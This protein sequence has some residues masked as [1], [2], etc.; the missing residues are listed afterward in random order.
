VNPL[1]ATPTVPGH[2]LLQVIGK[3]NSGEVWLAQTITGSLRAVK[4]V[5]PDQFDNLRSYERELEGV[6]RFEP[7]SRQHESLMDV[8]HVGEDA[9][10]RCF[11]CVME[12]ADSIAGSPGYT[13]LTLR[14]HLSTK[15]RLP[16]TE[17]IEI[18]RRLAEGL[19]FL[20]EHGL[21]HRDVK[22]GNVIFCRGQ[23]K[24]ADVGLV[25]GSDA[26]L[27]FVGTEGYFPPEGPG[28]P[29]ADLYSLG[30]VI[31]E[32]ATGKHRCE[33]PA[34][35]ASFTDSTE[36]QAFAEL[37]EIILKACAT[38]PESRYQTAAELRRDLLLLQA[39]RSITQQRLAERRL[40]R[41]KRLGIGAAIVLLV[42][43][44]AVGVQRRA[45]AK[46]RQDQLADEK[47]AAEE[48][49]RSRRIATSERETRA[50]LYAADLS[51]AASALEYGA[52]GRAVA[53]LE[54]HLPTSGQPDL[55]GIEWRLLRRKC[56]S[57]PHQVIQAHPGGVRAMILS[58][59]GK[60][61]YSTGRDRTLRAFS[62]ASGDAIKSWALP[63]AE[64]TSMAIHPSS[65][66]LA[67]AGG[68]EGGIGLLDLATGNL[69][70]QALSANYQVGFSPDGTMVLV[71]LAARDHGT[72]GW[73]EMFDLE[74]RPVR[75][76]ATSGCRFAFSPK[77]TSLATGPWDELVKLWSWPELQ[78]VREL[79]R[80]AEVMSLE[81]APDGRALA[82]G[83][84]WGELSR[85]DTES[86]IKPTRGG[87]RVTFDTVTWSPD[88][89]SV[90]TTFNQKVAIFDAE[91]L[92]LREQFVGHEKTVFSVRWTRDGRKIISASADGT[93]R[94]W[95][96]KPPPL[97][98]P[99]RGLA[100]APVFSAD[101]QWMAAALHEG[102]VGVWHTS[103]NT[104][105][106]RMTASG[107]LLGFD[108]EGLLLALERATNSS[109]TTLSRRSVPETSALGSIELESFAS[110][111]RSPVLNETATCLAAISDG[112]ISCWNVQTGKILKEFPVTDSDSTRRPTKVIL[113]P[114]GNHL[115]VM[116]E[117]GTSLVR[118]IGVESTPM[119][120]KDT[121]SV[122]FAHKTNWV[123]CGTRDGVIEI[124]ALGSGQPIA[125]LTGPRSPIVALA[126][127][128]DDKTLLGRTAHQTLHFWKPDS[129]RDA[130]VIHPMKPG[131]FQLTSPLVGTPV[132]R[133]DG[134]AVA[135]SGEDG[136]LS[137]WDAP[138]ESP[139]HGSRKVVAAR[140]R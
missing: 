93:I 10:N 57:H 120:F 72:N 36:Q 49:E 125:K 24:L 46:A 102:G 88:G 31:Y 99:I 34:A 124:R 18:A 110:M 86:D 121:G 51:L 40:A 17:C 71:G 68:N 117:D 33:F 84:F 126:F 96:S 107:T 140:Q 134:L 67:V 90:A 30:V 105:A 81:F 85:W 75:K 53:S 129:S 41:W 79:P 60:T 21:V 128:P 103:S 3:G 115:A 92:V 73:I 58:Q 69:R 136:G 127:S 74:L 44:T 139:S 131:P 64:P 138:E 23:P 76:L 14:S 48:A 65:P 95:A 91:R 56:F 132:F 42:G 130:L 6:R 20:H 39:G 27:S 83:T 94:V 122:G 25:T 137:I 4:L 135:L 113:S 28:R 116:H 55:R 45:A 5:S 89:N 54:A 7:L 112:A 70:T 101:S 26:T 87:A 37:N 80:V 12:L 1:S 119:E 38:H 11:Y 22:P 62:A 52:I 15:G 106:G 8:L 111:I 43:I 108:P 16:V 98:Q 97:Q 47:R 133:P 66:L 19:R 82:C 63:M 104:L 118:H 35:P 109:T 2:T 50:A 77:A 114:N 32:M 78:P 13:P 61:I 100:S 9:P 29:Q 59:D 123:A